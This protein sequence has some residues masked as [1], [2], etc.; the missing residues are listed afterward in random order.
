MYLRE[1]GIYSVLHYLPLHLPDM[2]KRYGGKIG[3]FPVAEDI[4][5]RLMRLPF[6]NG[7]NSADQEQVIETIVK[8]IP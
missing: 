6:H 8:F 2:G 4:S 1:R 5:D 7:L 3:E